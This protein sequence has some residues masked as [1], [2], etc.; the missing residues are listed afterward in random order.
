MPEEDEQ[1][2]HE[3]IN[4]IPVPQIA[5]SHQRSQGA[6]HSRLEYLGY[7]ERR[8][9][10]AVLPEVALKPDGAG[11][12]GAGAGNTLEDTHCESNPPAHE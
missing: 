2:G 12:Q 5:L 6:I 9:T 11:T 7:V 3:F 8:I 10:R 1:L 4:R